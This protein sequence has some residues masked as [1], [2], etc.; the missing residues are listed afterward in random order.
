MRKLIMILCL[1]SVMG[2]A[3]P[4]HPGKGMRVSTDIIGPFSGSY[5]VNL[6]NNQSDSTPH[7]FFR[8]FTADLNEWTEFEI[9]ELSAELRSRGCEVS[10]TSP[11]TLLVKV[12]NISSAESFAAIRM[13]VTVSLS[14]PDG[15]WSKTVEANE[16]SGW[17]AGRA[18]GGVFYRI[19][20]MILNDRE[21][22][23]KMRL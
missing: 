21:I 9:S 20:E 17:S 6:I 4:L 14:S 23:S 10:E 5:S 11:N 2:C 16:A 22:M 8:H 13:F 15:S 19:N 3:V 1:L 7:K 12:V 18:I